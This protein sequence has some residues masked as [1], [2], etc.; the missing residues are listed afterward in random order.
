MNAAA[1]TWEPMP[2]A[3]P[4]D[5]RKVEIC[6]VSGQPAGDYCYD[7]IPDPKGGKPR[8]VRTAYDEYVRPG[9]EIE[10]RCE[11]HQK[12]SDLL[13]GLLG[14]TDPKDTETGPDLALNAVIPE[15]P[16][17]VGADPYG[18]LQS[19]SARP[20][21]PQEAT[22]VMVPRVI[23]EDGQEVKVV[24]QPDDFVSFPLPRPGRLELTDE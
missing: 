2:P 17:L 14:A 13:A 10:G 16:I 3:P 7:L 24:E 19:P 22:P 12:D 11:L 1:A 5:A 20:T 21:G 4:A 6:R 23:G 9:T 18:S 8:L 15:V